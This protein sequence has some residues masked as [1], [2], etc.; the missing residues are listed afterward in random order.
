MLLQNEKSVLTMDR[1]RADRILYGD[2]PMFH[3]EAMVATDFG[4]IETA[5]L[6]NNDHNL[7]E[8]QQL[9]SSE[10]SD[11]IA[12][13]EVVRQQD[14]PAPK[15]ESY[16][17]GTSPMPKQYQTYRPKV[18][19]HFPEVQI[20]EGNRIVTHFDE[21]LMTKVAEADVVETSMESLTNTRH[22]TEVVAN[23]ETYLRLNTKGLIV[24]ATFFA[25]TAL[26]IALVVINGLAIGA[27]AANIDSLR[28]ENSRLQGIHTDAINDRSVAYN[29]GVNQ[30]GSG[31]SIVPGQSVNSIPR[32]YNLTDVQSDH[33]TNLFDVIARFLTS[34]FR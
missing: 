18:I 19:E 7:D 13:A 4:N 11:K 1:D 9:V 25:V 10:Y 26:I 8:Y 3:N 30:A 5:R 12:V 28:A 32:H 33:S 34:L 29:T 17:T 21:A 20:P 31:S 14:V 23:T 2:E 15:F 22:Q 24:C 27:S 16:Y 6:F